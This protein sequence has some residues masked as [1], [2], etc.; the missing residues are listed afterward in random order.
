MSLWFSWPVALATYAVV[1]VGTHL[2]GLMDVIMQRPWAGQVEHL[3]YVLVGYQ[4][5]TVAFGDEPLRW[6][7]TPLGKEMML[8]LAMM[9]DTITGVVLFQSN[10][11]IAKG[12][13]AGG[14]DPLAQTVT[15]GAIMWVG[16]DG[17]MIVVM[18][19]LALS[20]LRRSEMAQRMISAGWLMISAG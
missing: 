19:I 12:G 20:W 3:V 17:L 13:V 7:L 2:T 15:G 11:A 18:L 8:V 5:F 9:V 10:Q 1:I 14:I 4:F 16:G 6:R